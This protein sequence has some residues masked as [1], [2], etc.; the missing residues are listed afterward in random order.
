[1]KKL[2][3]ILSGMLISTGVMAGKP[4]PATC[5][6][7][8]DALYDGSNPDPATSCFDQFYSSKS[9]STTINNLKWQVN[10]ASY[11]ALVEKRSGERACRGT[12]LVAQSL[13]RKEYVACVEALTLVAEDADA[14]LPDCG[15]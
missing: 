8:F 1:M 15:N 10:G 11:F 4:P 2:P 9:G 12:Y 6:C 13:S 14:T 7:D 5:P 3:L